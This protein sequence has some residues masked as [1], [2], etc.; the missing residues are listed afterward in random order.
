MVI[1][2]VLIGL[3]I[4]SY[5]DSVVVFSLALLFPFVPTKCIYKLTDAKQCLCCDTVRINTVIIAVLGLCWDLLSDRRTAALNSI[6]ASIRKEK[7]LLA[8]SSGFT[9]V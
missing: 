1:I 6:L 2:Q 9:F 5:F 8:C 7:T 3:A 4:V